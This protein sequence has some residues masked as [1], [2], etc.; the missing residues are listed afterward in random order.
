[1][2][3]LKLYKLKKIYQF[4]YNIK[5]RYNQKKYDTTQNKTQTRYKYDKATHTHIKKKKSD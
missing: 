5:I 4:L 2:N 1:M 3:I